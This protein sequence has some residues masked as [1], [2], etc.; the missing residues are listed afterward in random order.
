MPLTLKCFCIYTLVTL[1]PIMH[2]ELNLVG[3]TTAGL[4]HQMSKTSIKR[5]VPRDPVGT[6]TCMDQWQVIK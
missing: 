1:L 2:P 6:S 3:F 4:G 5:S